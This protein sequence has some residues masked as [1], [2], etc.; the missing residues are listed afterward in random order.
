MLT[1]ANICF[2]MRGA[3]QDNNDDQSNTNKADLISSSSVTIF[4]TSIFTLQWGP[5]PRKREFWFLNKS[6]GLGYQNVYVKDIKREK[7]ILVRSIL[8]VQLRGFK[9]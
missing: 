3:N 4:C 1:G 7:N 2:P 6:K 5:F 9:N 8:Y